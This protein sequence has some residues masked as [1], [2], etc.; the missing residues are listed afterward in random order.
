MKQATPTRRP[1]NGPKSELIVMA[2]EVAILASSSL[3]G[4]SIEH[5]TKQQIEFY[6]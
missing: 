2:T 6:D 1:Y 5:F 4:S 3:S